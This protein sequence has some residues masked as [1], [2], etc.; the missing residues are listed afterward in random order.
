MVLWVVWPHHN[1]FVL[2]G[3]MVSAY[4]VGTQSGVFVSVGV[5]GHVGWEE[6]KEAGAVQMKI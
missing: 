5:E 3:R 4:R 1:E 2:K 6:K